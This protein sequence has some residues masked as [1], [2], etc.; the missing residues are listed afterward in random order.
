M[1]ASIQERTERC[2]RAGSTY[3]RRM[4]D[5]DRSASRRK[6]SSSV[7]VCARPVGSGPMANGSDVFFAVRSDA[8]L[9]S[10]GMSDLIPKSAARAATGSFN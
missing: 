2:R 10:G 7:E 3:R 4:A 8:I 9:G 6:P 5:S 1:H